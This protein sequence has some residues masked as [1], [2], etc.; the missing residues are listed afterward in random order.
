MRTHVTFQADFPKHSEPGAP[1]GR[2]LAAFLLARL[3]AAGYVAGDPRVHED[4]AYM[5]VCRRD[6]HAFV[7]FVA[8]V[9]DGPQEWLVYA[10]P[11]VGVARR[12]LEKMR[13]SAANPEPPELGELC[14][15]IH[16]CL[17]ADQH[18]RTI[19]WYTTEGWDTN[20]DT[21]WAGSP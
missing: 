14:G 21:G 20:P 1:A 8:L 5:F 6:K 3:N 15:T 18:F 16:R 12:W 11:E 10:E 19:R 7:I 9:D 2:E 17:R 13:L 4:Y